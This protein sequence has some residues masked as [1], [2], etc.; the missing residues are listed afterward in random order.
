MR[1]IIVAGLAMY[2]AL[3]G[4]DSHHDFDPSADTTASGL[5]CGDLDL[6][7][8]SS[9]D[10]VRQKVVAEGHCAELRG[11]QKINVLKTVNVT[12]VGKYSQILYQLEDGH[13]STVWVID[14]AI[15]GGG[16]RVAK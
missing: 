3:P 16:V 5:V 12:G 9:N 13:S 1:S 11:S 10:I 8:A 15:R 4:C 14:S 7:L 6:L 2:L